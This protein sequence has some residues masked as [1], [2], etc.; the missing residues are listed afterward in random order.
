MWKH[1]HWFLT[2]RCNLECVHCFRPR[3]KEKE[4][5]EK[6]QTLAGILAENAQKVT[7]TG[8]EPT[9]VPSF[10]ATA[11]FLKSKGIVTCLHTN[12]ISLDGRFS[13]LKGMVDD[14]AVPLDSLDSDVQEYLKGRDYLPLAL[15]AIEQIRSAGI[16][17]GVHTVFC[18]Q[19]AG[20]IPKIHRFLRS[21]GYSYWNVYEYTPDL[22]ADRFTSCERF[23][24]V[25]GLGGSSSLEKGGTDSLFG[26]FLEAEALIRRT[27]DRRLNFV[28]HNDVRPYVFLDSNGELYYSV[29]FS[30]KRVRIGNLLEQ[31]YEKVDEELEKA[32]TQGILFDQESFVELEQDKPLFARLYEGNYDNE[33]LDEV[34]G[35]SWN[36]IG[37][38]HDLYVARVEREE[39]KPV[40]I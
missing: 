17:L 30:G 22:V 29:F 26:R 2:G 9:L 40:L 7:F 35:R 16:K 38:L 34:D 27:K 31:G 4:C 3:L 19:N 11:D 15:R 14:I 5:F 25:Q 36:K 8:G 23:L 24:Q 1:V 21:Q 20:S 13:E 37:R 32:K 12:G 33:E 28:S 10:F 39:K 6:I 18:D